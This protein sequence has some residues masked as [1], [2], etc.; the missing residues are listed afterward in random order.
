M[1]ADGQ[2]AGLEVLVHP[3]VCVNIS[4]HFTRQRL[5]GD[6]KPRVYGML[7][8]KL[9]G[10]KVEII[11]SAEI[12]IEKDTID[13]EYVKMRL[14]QYNRVFEGNLILGWY[15]AST[16]GIQD[17]DMN[18]H[19]QMESQVDEKVSSPFFLYLNP[20]STATRELPLQIYEAAYKHAGQSSKYF[21]KIPFGVETSE[22][23]RIAVDTVASVTRSGASPLASHLSTLQSA[24]KMLNSRVMVIKRY[25]EAVKSGALKPD[26]ALLR[27]IS[28]LCQQLPAIQTA[29]FKHDFLVD[30]NDAL[31]IT[32]LAAITK[33]STGISEMMEKFNA[34]YDPRAFRRRGMF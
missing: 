28:A 31:L 2:K 18:L 5:T 20:A 4:D 3:M 25:L 11:N 1:S 23:E 7:M 10:R 19:E 9:S 32:Y 8:G 14:E 13:A 21:Q 15:A 33:T 34:T 12:I 17:T 24:V 22:I 27:E 26:Y 29:E 30:Y 16:N 6:A